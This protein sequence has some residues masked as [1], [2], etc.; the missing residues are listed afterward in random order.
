L[1]LST[2]RFAELDET[3]SERLASNNGTL[4][5]SRGQIRVHA[6]VSLISRRG[7]A[8][9]PGLCFVSRSAENAALHPDLVARYT[10]DD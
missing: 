10:A 3:R 8:S 6:G 9:L 2:A 1:R 7:I 5:V 4:K